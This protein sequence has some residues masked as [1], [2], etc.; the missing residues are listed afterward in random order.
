MT[1]VD[2]KKLV[3]VIQEDLQAIINDTGATIEVSELPRIKGFQT[4][5]RLL[6]QN[7]ISNSIKFSKPG[8]APKI[9][10]SAKE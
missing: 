3:E 2:C 10:L 6:F 5:L 9:V 7:L 1:V 8:I 4:E